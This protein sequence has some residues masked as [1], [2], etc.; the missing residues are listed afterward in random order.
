MKIYDQK[1]TANYKIPF[2]KIPIT[3]WINAD[4]RYGMNYHWKAG[5]INVPDSLNF[6]NIIQ[7]SR[8]Q[9][10]SGRL[11]MVKLYNKSKFLKKINTPPRPPSRTQQ[12]RQPVD[13]TK[14]IPEAVKGFFRLLMSLRSINF[15][16]TQTEG[17]ILPRV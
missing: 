8:D 5:P 16:F 12:A 11:D 10:L 17:T 13:T 2:D 14:Q 1:I 7:N 9:N 6:G 15:T 3:D 4:Y